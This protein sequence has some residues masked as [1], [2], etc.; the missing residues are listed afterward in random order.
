MKSS[1]GN[2]FQKVTRLLVAPT[3]EP[4]QRAARIQTVEKDIILPIKG[5]LSV[6]LIS[7]FFF[8]DWTDRDGS[9]R[10]ATLNVGREFLILYIALNLAAGIVFVRVR[11]LS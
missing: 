11:Q 9:L 3:V 6:L 7:Y 8:S 10:N 1:D 4:G 2:M 5:L